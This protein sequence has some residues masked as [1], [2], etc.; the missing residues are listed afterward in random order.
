MQ[1]RQKQAHLK[2]RALPH[3]ALGFQLAAHQVGQHLGNRQTQARAAR[4]CC[5]AASAGR[6]RI[7]PREGFKNTIQ[8][9]RRHAGPGVV[10]FNVGHFACI[11]QHQAHATVGGELDGIAQQ[12]DTNLAHPLLIRT[13]PLWHAAHHLILKGQA[14]V[15]GLQ[16]KHA[17]QLLHA[18]GELHGLD[19]QGQLAALNMG[20]VQRALNQG[21]QML[22]AALDHADRLLAVR[23]NGR[24]FTHEL[25]VTQD[26]VQRRAQL[27]AYGADIAALG[28]VGM[29]GGFARHFGLQL[30]GLQGFIGLAVRFNLLHQQMGLSV[31]LFLGHLA[32]FM[33][34]H[35][36]PGDDAR[37][38]Q[39]RGKGF[40]KPR[41]QS[42]AQELLAL[43]HLGQ[44][45]QLLL[46]EQTK[47]RSQQRYDD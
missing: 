27:V 6:S 39:Q 45:G 25:R 13:H 9:L 8:L 31:G 20:N 1:L 3:H 16:F 12:V 46:V 47:H 34:Q 11:A 19:V 5:R 38:Q 10:D 36:P 18:A 42:G 37:H 43:H 17:G 21:Q 14:F 26:A 33:R 29:F 28:L 30:G 22:T 23:R 44:P 2:H 41:L 4:G 35:Q 7:T 15:G 40:A 24:V 32:A